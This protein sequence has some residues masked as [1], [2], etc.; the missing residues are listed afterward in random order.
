MLPVTNQRGF[1]L[2]LTM[3]LS[4][5]LITLVLHAVMLLN[6]DRAYFQASF[7]SF[8]L[9]QLRESALADID[10]QIQK[11]TLP[12]N[13]TFVYDRGTAIFRTNKS[14]DNLEVLFTIMS[15]QSKETD[16]IIYSLASGRPIDWLERTEP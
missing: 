1:I 2:P 5:L 3:I 9:Q 13:G 7:A 12:E 10:E 16:K 11:K 14:R 8:Q 6:S 4:L 15:D